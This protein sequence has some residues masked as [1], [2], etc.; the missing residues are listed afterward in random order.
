M[1]LLQ[2]CKSI[3]PHGGEVIVAINSDETIQKLKGPSRPINN[4]QA[5]VAILNNIESV[6]WVVVFKEDTPHEILKQI[7]PHTLVKGGDYTIDSIIGKEFCDNVRVFT[8]I[9]GKSTTGIIDK[10]RAPM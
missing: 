10:I 4:E 7:R 3:K 5:R 9:D 6:D 1:A 2:F 8:Y